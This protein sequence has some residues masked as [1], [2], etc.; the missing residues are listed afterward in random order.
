MREGWQPR[1]SA[2]FPTPL[3]ST[4]THLQ[5]LLLRHHLAL[6][7]EAIQRLCR[8]RLLDLQGP[9]G[10]A[11]ESFVEQRNVKGQALSAAAGC[12]CSASA[13]RAR[14]SCKRCS[15][16]GR[17]S[18]CAAPAPAARRSHPSPPT[19]PLPTQAKQTHPELVQGAA[20]PQ[21]QQQGGQRL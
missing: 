17:R 20:V 21:A 16:G 7:A 2:P 11:H 3:P 18:T 15:T 12:G 10:K 5:L 6:R 4:P 14:V 13:A 8:A 9:G 1:A 19:P